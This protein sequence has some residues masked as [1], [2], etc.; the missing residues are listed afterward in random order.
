GYEL[1][2]LRMG[3]KP[4]QLFKY[5]SFA[6]EDGSSLVDYLPAN[7]LIFI[8]EI[9]RVQEMND[10]LDKEEAEWYTS[11]LGEGQIIHDVKV[12]HTLKEFLHRSRHSITYMSL[13]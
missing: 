12:S 5:L 11:L 3:N 4:E 9:S 6:F 2:Q 8:D 13:F 7:G 10:T 1:E